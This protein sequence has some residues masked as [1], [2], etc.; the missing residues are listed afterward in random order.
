MA[1]TGRKT[2]IISK[3]YFLQACLERDRSTLECLVFAAQAEK[4]GLPQ[5]S[6]L[7]GETARGTKG[8]DKNP[9]GHLST[10]NQRKKDDDLYREA[11]K[12]LA[13]MA[14]GEYYVCA[15]CGSCWE[16]R[17][18]ERCPQCRSE[19]ISFIRIG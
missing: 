13:E 3:E 19:A 1:L 14:K 15:G 6:A 5:I 17:R 8:E 18:P 9:S 7:I 12:R 2:M 10:N 11:L 16:Q 4:E